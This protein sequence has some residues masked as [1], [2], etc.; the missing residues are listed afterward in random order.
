MSPPRHDHSGRCER[1]LQ[2][3]MAYVDGELT[4][5]RRRE[6]ERHL[7]ACECCGIMADNVRAVVALCRS[8]GKTPVPAPLRARAR[9]RIRALMADA[10]GGSGAAAAP[11]AASKSAATRA[12][13]ARGAISGRAGRRSRE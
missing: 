7:A 1:L 4:R 10:S 5:E 2:Q 13:T 12:G 9:A 8:D 11:R 6:V 3:L